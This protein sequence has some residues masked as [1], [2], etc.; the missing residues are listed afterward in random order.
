MKDRKSDLLQEEGAE[1]S[2]EDCAQR[3]ADQDA[4]DARD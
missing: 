1:P 3:P 2:D 4:E